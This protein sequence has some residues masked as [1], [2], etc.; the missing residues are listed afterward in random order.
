M[1]TT[2][3]TIPPPALTPAIAAPIATTSAAAIAAR[4][5]GTL[6]GLP[7]TAPPAALP[8]LPP[9][10]QQARPP[11]DSGPDDDPFAAYVWEKENEV[12][13]FGHVRQISL[14]GLPPNAQSLKG[15]WVH[16]T[17]QTRLRGNFLRPPYVD[18]TSRLTSDPFDQV[19]CYHSLTSL[20]LYLKDKLGFD[21]ARI[22][23]AIKP[24]YAHVNAARDV[25]AWFDPRTGHLTFGT[26]DKSRFGAWHLAEDADIVRHECGHAI[27]HCMNPELAS[28]YAGDGGAIHE[29]FADSIAA[30]YANNPVI[31]EDFL[32]NTGE[33]YGTDRGLRNVNNDLRYNEV[34]SEVHSLGQVYGGFWWGVRKALEPMLGNGRDAADVAMSILMNHGAHYATNMPT[35]KDFFEAALA[36]AKIYLEGSKRE[37]EYKKVARAITEEAK[38]R[39]FLDEAVHKR[40]MRRRFSE[41]FGRLLT[42][43]PEPFAFVRENSVGN[44]AGS[45]EFYQQ[46]LVLEKR[47]FVRMLG[48]GLIVFKDGSGAARSFSASDM[49]QSVDVDPA[50]KYGRPN[51]LKTIKMAAKSNLDESD[52]RLD[53]LDRQ[54]LWAGGEKEKKEKI[55][56]AEALRR[57]DEV[58]F[59][60]AMGQEDHRSLSLVLMPEEPGSSTPERQN[61]HWAIQLGLTVFFVNAKSGAV[62]ARKI[63]MWDS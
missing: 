62:V 14:P 27:L 8:G 25:N 23:S 10:A 49:R 41:E 15:E 19:Q 31:S 55:T 26:G 6:P 9:E 43:A 33:Q 38:R 48:S 17:G 35:P 3:S 11:D 54:G 20:I 5:N 61:L 50:I 34:D 2:I 57:L 29:G 21:M 45:R 18:K 13:S 63:A 28:W 4:V 52:K 53:E 44:L 16:V 47:H 37:L 22:I 39:G 46:F 60:E 42:E 1:A 36:G 12:T 7:P 51:A 24:I 59:E 58:A 30:F 56:R 40:G 32:P